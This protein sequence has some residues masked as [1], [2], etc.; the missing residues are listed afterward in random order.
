VS[1]A[2]LSAKTNAMIP[3]DEL[4]GSLTRERVSLLVRYAGGR[5]FL[6]TGFTPARLWLAHM[7]DTEIPVNAFE[8]LC[9]AGT[10][11]AMMEDLDLEL[12]Y[13]TPNTDADRARLQADADDIFTHCV[14]N[15]T[16]LLC[17]QLGITA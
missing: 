12:W 11:A 13:D 7:L 1:I 5:A 10:T 14:E 6:E 8:A 2:T 17:T 4:I 3:E 16:T 15:L 9:Q